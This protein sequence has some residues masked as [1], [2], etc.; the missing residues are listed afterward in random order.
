LEIG[1]FGISMFDKHTKSAA[2]HGLVQI[3]RQTIPNSDMGISPYA[4]YH[5]NKGL[6]S[7]P[8]M[9]VWI[10]KQ[11]VARY[12]RSIPD[13]KQSYIYKHSIEGYKGLADMKVWI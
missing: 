13:I 7:I 1:M 11:G 8:N 5:A 6:S 12:I 3:M 9:I 2:F 4:L 10:I